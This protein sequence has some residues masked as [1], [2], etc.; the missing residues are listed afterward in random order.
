[1][2]V[3]GTRAQVVQPGRHR[4]GRGPEPAQQVGD[5]TAGFDDELAQDGLGAAVGLLARAT[6]YQVRSPPAELVAVGLVGDDPPRF[7]QLGV[8]AERGE[9]CGV[10]LLDG[11]PGT[12]DRDAETSD[13]SCDVAPDFAVV[14]SPDLRLRVAGCD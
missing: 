2:P 9:L 3:L 1:M 6:P 12:L 8:D 10:L 7:G 4:L 13:L 14:A 5:E 11:C